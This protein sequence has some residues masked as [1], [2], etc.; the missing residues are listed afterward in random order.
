MFRE[1]ERRRPGTFGGLGGALHRHTCPEGLHVASTEGERSILRGLLAGATWTAGR[2]AGHGILRLD[3]CPFCRGAPETEPH[4]LWDYPRWELAR[5]AWMPWVLQE[6]RALPALALPAAWPVCLRATRLLLLAPVGEGEDAQAGRLLYKL[7]ACTSP[8]C[9]P[10][11][12]RRRRRGWAGTQP[13]WCLARHGGGARICDRGTGGSSWSMVRC[14]PPKHETLRSCRG[15]G[16]WGGR[17]SAALRTPWCTGPQRYTGH[18]ARTR[19]LTPS[20]PLTLS[21]AATGSPPARPGHRHAQQVLLLREWARVLREAVNLLQPLLAGRTLLEGNFRWMCASLVPLGAFAAWAGPTCG[22]TCSNSNNTAWSS[23]RA[24]CRP[25]GPAA[26]TISS[27][28]ICRTAREGGGGRLA[29]T[30]SCVRSARGQW[31]WH[32]KPQCEQCRLARRGVAHY[33]AWGHE[34]HPVAVAGAARTPSGSGGGSGLVKGPAGVVG[35]PGAATGAAS[36]AP[37]RG[38]GTSGGRPPSAAGLP[39]A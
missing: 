5:R 22:S 11:A 39:H 36:Q 19:S 16:W 21:P 26:K 17:G 30:R 35:A 13:P 6:A 3:K 12:R 7:M 9:R 14:A 29:R 24:G 32:L 18:R 33:C 28:G 34:G 2:A 37:L 4:I 1:L 31:V 10:A 27:Q 8:C 20:W 23:G 38:A 15:A 25:Q